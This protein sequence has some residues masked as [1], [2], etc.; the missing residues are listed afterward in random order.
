M[1]SS[2]GVDVC[3][4]IGISLVISRKLLRL[5]NGDVQYLREAGNK[6]TFIVSLQLAVK[7]P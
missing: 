1:F 2:D 6:S 7:L 4:E 3:D 5:M